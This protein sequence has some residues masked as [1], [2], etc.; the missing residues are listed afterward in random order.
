MLTGAMMDAV[1][2]CQRQGH[3]VKEADWNG[4]EAFQCDECG[5]LAWPTVDMTTIRP[6]RQLALTYC[7]AIIADTDTEEIEQWILD[8][9][10]EQVTPENYGEVLSLVKDKAYGR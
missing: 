4:R 1:A 3:D 2:E 9:G 6:E 8:A 10:Y 5:I 7:A